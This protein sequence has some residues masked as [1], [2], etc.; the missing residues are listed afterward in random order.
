L[1]GH[2]HT[3][4]DKVERTFIKQRGYTLTSNFLEKYIHINRDYLK[5]TIG[6][7]K[8]NSQ[9][10][11]NKFANL[12]WNNFCGYIINVFKKGKSSAYFID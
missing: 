3:N 12:C 7:K 10:L 2:K 5:I 1:Y 9:K 4:L 8:M 6:L 11:A